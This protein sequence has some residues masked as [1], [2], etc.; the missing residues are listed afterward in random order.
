MVWKFESLALGKYK[1]KQKKKIPVEIRQVDEEGK[2]VGVKEI[3]TFRFIVRE[4]GQ[5]QYGE[6]NVEINN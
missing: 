4:A 1:S 2:Q 3:L 5:E 6:L